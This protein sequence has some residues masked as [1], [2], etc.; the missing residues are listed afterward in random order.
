VLTSFLIV[1]HRKFII[2]VLILVISQLTKNLNPL[3][4]IKMLMEYFE[5]DERIHFDPTY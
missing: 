3:K 1:N 4:I 2:L 5:E